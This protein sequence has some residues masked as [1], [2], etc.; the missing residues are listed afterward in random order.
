[1]EDTPSASQPHIPVLCDAL[2]ERVTLK[3]NSV[4]VDATVCY[5]GHAM[6]SL[7]RLGTG[8]TFIGL[9]VDEAALAVT[10]QRFSR[11]GCRVELIRENFD[12][13]GQVLD[14]LGF[15]RADF[16]LADLGMNSAQLNDPQRGFSF[17]H[18]GPLDMRLDQRLEQ[19]AEDL[20][21]RLEQDALADLIYQYG[22]ERRSRRIAKGIVEARRARRITRTGQLAEL[23]LGAM[24]LKSSRGRSRIHPATRTF[25]ALRIA[26]N[27]EVGRLEAF[28]KQIPERLADDGMIAVISFH[29]L[30]DRP[31]KLDFRHNK[32]L[33][34]YRI[35]TKKPIVADESE[36]RLN[37]RSR[38]AKLRIAQRIARHEA[39]AAT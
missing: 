37:P 17:Q 26:V 36:S 29:S 21:N 31:V 4:V 34:N 13:I 20:V 39:V 32:E 16:I 33:G 28:L 9:D 11:A 15:E 1:M 19:S 30:E 23:V 8:G 12:R 24:G 6:H 5:G 22:E 35:L 14:K 25:Q 27:N 3:E 18:D 7:S 10:R 2:F 38:S